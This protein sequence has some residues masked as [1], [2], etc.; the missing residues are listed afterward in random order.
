MLHIEASIHNLNTIREFV[1]SNAMALGIQQ[2]DIF[3]VV[4]SV[5]EAATNIIVHGYQGQPGQIDIEVKRD[6]TYLMIEMRD[7]ALP[8]DPT[9][10]PAPALTLP[11]DERPIGGLGIHLMR[12]YMDQMDYQYTTDGYNLLTLKKHIQ[13]K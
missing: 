7:Q 8:F 2:N 3:G 9:R 1:R 13:E 4:L 5:D 6:K 10:V 12:Q 11:L